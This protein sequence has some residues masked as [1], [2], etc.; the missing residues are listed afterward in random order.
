M[1]CDPLMI[2]LDGWGDVVLMLFFLVY[3]RLWCYA[4]EG[5]C[6]H[7][8]IGICGLQVSCLLIYFSNLKKSIVLF[9]YSSCSSLFQFVNNTWSN[10]LF[11]KS[12]SCYFADPSIQPS[13]SSS[14]T[15]SS[16]LGVK[17]TFSVIACFTR[18]KCFKK[19][20]QV[21]PFS[22]YFYSSFK[23][24]IFI[25]LGLGHVWAKVNIHSLSL[26]PG[27][28]PYALLSAF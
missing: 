12:M 24:K 20:P 16:S 11:G 3:L 8:R 10:P 18:S 4:L 25:F 14:S 13:R 17:Y 6:K 1:W 2:A 23:L 7:I 19:D 26:C 15:A 5:F 28:L 9:S 27:W 22:P 21:W